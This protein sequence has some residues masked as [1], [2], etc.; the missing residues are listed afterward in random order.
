[1]NRIKI[2]K[3][4]ISVLTSACLAYLGLCAYYYLFQTHIIYYPSKTVEATPKDIGLAYHDLMLTTSD[5]VA[6]NAWYV[7]APNA[8]ATILF[9]HG[10]AGNIGNRLETVRILHGLGANVLIYDYRGFGK[11]E[12]SPG[13]E[14]TYRDAEAAWEYLVGKEAMAPDRII[15]WGRSLG[16]AVAVELAMRKKAGALVVES[17]FTSVATVA[18]KVI[19]YLPVDLLVR[20]RYASIEKVSSITAPALFIH[21]PYD[22]VI[23][24]AQG[25][26]LFERSASVPKTFLAI[27]G[28]HNAGFLVSGRIYTDAIDS[29]ITQHFGPMADR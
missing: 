10:N 17:G 18:K 2:R 28:N 12:G 6:I 7:P 11:S 3:L 5:R 4:L 1:M 15:L 13:E 9:N 16:S 27:K 8:R 25:R 21:S 20:H 26:E 19:P 24:F 23:P 29:F 14:G 22:E